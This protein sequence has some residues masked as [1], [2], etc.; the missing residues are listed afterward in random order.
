MI[1]VWVLDGIMLAIIAFQILAGWT[2]WGAVLAAL[3]VGLSAYSTYN[4]TRSWLRK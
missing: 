2:F 3:C 4:V 1:A